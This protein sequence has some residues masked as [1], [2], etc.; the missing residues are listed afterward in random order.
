MGN[1]NAMIPHGDGILY[2]CG[3][4]L[5]HGNFLTGHRE[6]WGTSFYHKTSYMEF[7]GLW[8]DDKFFYG[9]TFHKKLTP[10][11]HIPYT[12]MLTEK[13][14]EEKKFSLYPN[15]NCPYNRGCEGFFELM[16]TRC[17]KIY[18]KC[19]KQQAKFRGKFLSKGFLSEGTLFH[20]NGNKRYV[21]KFSKILNRTHPDGVIISTT[22]RGRYN[23]SVFNDVPRI[24]SR[25]DTR[26]KLYDEK[27]SLI[28]I[29]PFKDGMR[30]TQMA[31]FI[32]ISYEVCLLIRYSH[33][34]K[35]IMFYYLFL[36]Q[37]EK[38]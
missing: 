5:Y 23:C 37:E 9:N 34:T 30:D 10:I 3:K 32:G 24:N 29:G 18:G 7:I 35:L 11:T 17:T 21:G 15:S 6:D 16:T 2:S 12:K 27:G 31:E 13:N 4:I 33:V 38:I 36:E 19:L 14:Y 28:Y 8:K 20:D 25:R 26:A 1:L 22:E